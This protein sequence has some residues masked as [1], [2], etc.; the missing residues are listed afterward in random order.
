MPTISSAPP[1]I[2][3]SSTAAPETMPSLTPGH[4]TE[5]ATSA[6]HETEPATSAGHETEPATSAGHETEPASS[7]AHETVL[8]TSAAHETEPATIAGHETEPAT[9]ADLK[10]EPGTGHETEPTSSAAHETEP[11]TSAAHETEPEPATSATPE[12]SPNSS[13]TPTPDTLP[14]PNRSL[15]GKLAE[16]IRR[17]K[18]KRTLPKPLE[19]TITEFKVESPATV[20]A[21][22][23]KKAKTKSVR[24]SAP[25]ESDCPKEYL[26][27][28]AYTDRLRFNNDVAKVVYKDD[29]A[30]LSTKEEF[31]KYLSQQQKWRWEIY[32][33]VTTL[34]TRVHNLVANRN[35]GIAQNVIRYSSVP[36]NCKSDDVRRCEKTAKELEKMSLR[37]ETTKSDMVTRR[38]L[39]FDDEDG[40]VAG[41]IDFLDEMVEKIENLKTNVDSFTS[42]VTDTLQNICRRFTTESVEAAEERRQKRR[43]KENLKKKRKSLERQVEKKLIDALLRLTNKEVAERVLT[44]GEGAK[45]SSDEVNSKELKA[46]TSADD[47]TV[48]HT[49]LVREYLDKNASK[50]I[51][52]KLAKCK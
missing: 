12:S 7:A 4:E 24:T 21:R 33:I 1:E 35:S 47:I 2:V 19:E 9:S 5:P 16:N 11:A 15:A 43:K 41:E 25:M 20:P 44:G 8:A 34:D 38:S 22:P 6:G 32:N 52:D 46:M 17:S 29:F 30:R 10:T 3:P 18:R 26:I 14:N 42:K 37:I 50:L 48:L 39:L 45:I 28:N 27:E 13:S 36:V 40:P 31:Q 23:T 51:K 49:I